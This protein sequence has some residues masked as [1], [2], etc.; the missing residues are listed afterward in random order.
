MDP[1]QKIFVKQV[2][3]ETIAQYQKSHPC[4]FTV[5][6]AGNLRAMTEVMDEEGANHGTIR[7]IFQF[8]RKVQDITGKVAGVVVALL[9][10][11]SLILGFKYGPKVWEWFK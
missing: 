7:I 3:E 11:G 2:V 10:L 5:K 6:E 1:S 4:Q 9:A 8:G